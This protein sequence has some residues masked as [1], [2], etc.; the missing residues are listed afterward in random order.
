MSDDSESLQ[1]DQI[2]L[3]LAAMGASFAQ[4]LCAAEPSL[5]RLLV[6][7][8]TRNCCMLDTHGE[9]LAADLLRTFVRALHDRDMFPILL[10]D[11]AQRPGSDSG[12]VPGF[13]GP[14]RARRR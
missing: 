13:S 5:H 1:V 11:A 3:A 2:A 8:A 4:V 10:D 9:A 14:T 7:A 12:A 6:D